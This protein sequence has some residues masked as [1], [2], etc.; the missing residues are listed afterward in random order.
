MKVNQ[1]WEALEPLEDISVYSSTP[2]NYKSP[3][4]FKSLGK[5]TEILT[6]S[7]L[8]EDIGN[9]NRIQILKDK[10]LKSFRR[11]KQIKL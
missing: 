5:I 11:I 2:A 7:L 9:K 6:Y 1:I 3:Y 4:K 8:I 10:F